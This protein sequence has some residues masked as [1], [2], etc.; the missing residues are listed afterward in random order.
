MKYDPSTK[1]KEFGAITMPTQPSTG[2]IR[3]QTHETRQP[4]EGY[5]SADDGKAA[6]YGKLSGSVTNPGQ[7]SYKSGPKST[8][9]Y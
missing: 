6:G 3:K 8:R 5:N 1:D 4:S 2:R 7:K 9:S